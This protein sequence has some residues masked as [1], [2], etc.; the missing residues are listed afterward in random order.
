MSLSVFLNAPKR[1]SCKLTLGNGCNCAKSTVATCPKSIL[2]MFHNTLPVNVLADIRKNRDLDTLQKQKKWVYNEWG[3]YTVTKLSKWNTM[4]LEKQLKTGPKNATGV[5]NVNVDTPESG[6]VQPPTPEM[7]SLQAQL[8]RMVKAAFS[9]AGKADAGKDRGRSSSRTPQRSRT[10]SQGS[11]GASRPRSNIPGPK[12]A[13][14]WC[15]GDQGHSRQKLPEFQ[16]IKDASNGKVPKDYECAYEKSTKKA[17]K[18]EIK[19]VTSRTAEAA[20]KGPSPSPELVET[21][22]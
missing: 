11:R 1:I 22:L 5:H 17:S 12:C 9:K 2:D 4:R 15:C 8:E 19:A 16:A 20:A 3:R 6:V 13:G 18:V 7:S 10:S 14:C 21:Y